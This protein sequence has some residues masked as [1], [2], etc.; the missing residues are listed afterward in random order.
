MKTTRLLND[1]LTDDK[2]RLSPPDELVLDRGRGRLLSCPA[3]PYNPSLS[4]CDQLIDPPS[5][6]PVGST[7]PSGAR[8]DARLWGALVVLCGVLFLDGLD[9]SMVGVALP[10]IRDD[11]HL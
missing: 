6:E 8:W 1:I 11:L 7:D 5:I 10:S 3:V 4:C 9:V 2:P